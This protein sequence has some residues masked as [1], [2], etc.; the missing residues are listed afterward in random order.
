MKT[1][2]TEFKPADP[3]KQAS[4]VDPANQQDTA[5]ASHGYTDKTGKYVTSDKDSYII[6]EGGTFAYTPKNGQSATVTVAH[7]G[8]TYTYTVNVLAPD[9]STFAQHTYTVTYITA[10]TH[11][12]QLTGILVDGTAVKG[13]DPARHEYNASV[14]DPDEWMVSPQYDKASGMTVSTEKKGADATI[15][16][17]SGDGLVKTTYKVH[18]T[19]KP[20]GGNG[21]NALGLA[22]TGV[23]IGWVGWLIGILAII[24]GALG[25]TAVTRKTKSNDADESSEPEPG[26]DATPSPDRSQNV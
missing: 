23:G 26:N 14:N 15:T 1:A 24:G 8:M 13:F 6:P 17:T 25:I 19:R 12:A 11:K 4:T 20:F 3:A 16:V 18:V 2:V 22:S 10:A 9:G 7:E 21:N 5:L